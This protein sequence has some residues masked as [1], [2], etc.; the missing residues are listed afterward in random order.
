VPAPCTVLRPEWVLS[1]ETKSA[2]NTSAFLQD[3]SLFNQF[4]IGRNYNP[5]RPSHYGKSSKSS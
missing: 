5:G 1:V 4:V 3:L 2:K